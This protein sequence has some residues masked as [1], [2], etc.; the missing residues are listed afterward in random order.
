MSVPKVWPFLLCI[1]S[2]DSPFKWGFDI[3]AACKLIT[4][5][6]PLVKRVYR[7]AVMSTLLNK[8][9]YDVYSLSSHDI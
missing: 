4:G 9:R 6:F 1:T 7:L 5:R 8:N 3:E 2:K